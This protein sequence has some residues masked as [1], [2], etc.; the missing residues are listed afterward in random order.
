MSSLESRP[1]PP[2]LFAAPKSDRNFFFASTKR[3]K[4]K[5]IMIQQIV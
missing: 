3:W 5:P 2:T 4:K 1:N